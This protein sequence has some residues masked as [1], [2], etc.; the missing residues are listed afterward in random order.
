MTGKPQGAG[1]AKSRGLGS[2]GADEGRWWYKAFFYRI[3]KMDKINKMC[4]KRADGRR[5]CS[6]C[7]C[8]AFRRFHDLPD[9]LQ[10]A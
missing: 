4:G 6:V 5:V 1:L 7:W 3:D 10:I 9:L 2:F 8:L